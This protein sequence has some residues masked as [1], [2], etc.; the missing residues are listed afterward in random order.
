MHKTYKIVRLFHMIQ[1]LIVLKFKLLQK[2]EQRAS[3]KSKKQTLDFNGFADGANR[4]ESATLPI[5]AFHKK[6]SHF[7][8]HHQLV[9]QRRQVLLIVHQRR[10]IGAKESACHLEMFTYRFLICK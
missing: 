8:S 10:Q 5:N 1:L 4:R 7:D 9:E 6:S 2:N 3:T